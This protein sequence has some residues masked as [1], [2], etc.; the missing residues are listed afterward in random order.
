[1]QLT[2]DKNVME[3][4]FGAARDA[5]NNECMGLLA[6]PRGSVMVTEMRLLPAIASATHAEA[7]PLALRACVEELLENGLI[8]CGIWHSHGGMQVFHSGTDHGTMERLLPAMAGWH[9]ERSPHVVLSPAVTAPDAA[10]LPLKD[11]RLIVFE[12]VGPGACGNELGKWAAV[13][14][15]FTGKPDAVPV[16]GFDGASLNMESNGVRIELGVPEGAT[17]HSRVEDRAPYRSST[18]YS[19]VVNT[20]RER[21]AECLEVKEFGG[22]CQTRVT[23]CEVLTVGA[24]PEGNGGAKALP[25][26]FRALVSR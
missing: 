15:K 10:L 4:I 6:S 5:G 26:F 1:M 17:V 3:R 24:G 20:R 11:G 23:A 9:F 2:I 25:T 21:F 12:V 14:T 16:A 18:L 13:S 22:R 8:P 7:S 19:L